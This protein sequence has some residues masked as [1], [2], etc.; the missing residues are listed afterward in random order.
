MRENALSLSLLFS[1]R[2]NQEFI[3]G[4]DCIGIRFWTKCCLMSERRVLHQLMTTRGGRRGTGKGTQLRIIDPS[5]RIS[6]QHRQGE[7]RDA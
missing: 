7:D 2:L 3:Q 5:I 4:I 6:M 1:A